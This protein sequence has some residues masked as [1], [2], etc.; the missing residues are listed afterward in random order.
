MQK[1]AAGAGA[2]FVDIG[3]ATGTS[4]TTPELNLSDN[5]SQYRCL[6]KNN[7]KPAGVA[8]NAAVLTVVTRLQIPGAPRSLGWSN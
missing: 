7:I 2:A 6:V 8:S 4:Y 3:G 1:K 5:Q